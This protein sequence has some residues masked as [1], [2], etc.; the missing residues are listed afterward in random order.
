MN[1]LTVLIGVAMMTY[2]LITLVLRQIRPAAF[3]KLEAMRQRFGNVPGTAIHV[4]AY[5]LVP[6][7]AGIVF[8]IRGL[9]GHSF[10]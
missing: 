9:A 10:L 5:S 7:G 6:I 4:I 1:L 8:I 2:G 3:H